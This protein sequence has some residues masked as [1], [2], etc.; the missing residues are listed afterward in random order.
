M[1]SETVWLLL[2]GDFVRPPRMPRADEVVIAVDGGMRHA[3]A[4]GVVPQWWL[5]D[6]DSSDGLDAASPRL[7]FPVEKDE[8]D[9]EL[10]LA[11]VRARWPQA[12]LWVLGADGDEADHGFANLWVL[13]RFGLPALLLGRNGTRAFASG[14]AA[15]QLCGQP[16]DKV[17]VFALSPLQGLRYQGLRWRADGLALP[18]FVA[19]AARNALAAEAATVRWQSGDGVVFTPPGVTVGWAG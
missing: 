8:T 17:S 2:A 9:F 15:W 12:H 16:G 11:F 1:M 14:A 13:P 3:A 5:G 7:S 18:P 10:A 19:L 4:L 6:F